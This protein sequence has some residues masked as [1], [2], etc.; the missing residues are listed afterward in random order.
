MSKACDDRK[1][2]SNRTEQMR[3]VTFSWNRRN[4]RLERLRKALFKWGES[5]TYDSV[6]YQRVILILKK[7][8]NLLA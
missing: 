2:A 7:K 3:D 5:K 6:A 8:V 1:D 4:I